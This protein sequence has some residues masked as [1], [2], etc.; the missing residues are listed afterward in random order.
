MIAALPKCAA[1]TLAVA[2]SL[3]GLPGSPVAEGLTPPTFRTKPKR[4]IGNLPDL[5]AR[6]A[7]SSTRNASHECLSRAVYFE[8]RGDQHLEGQLAVAQVV[9]NRTQSGLFPDTVCGVIRQPRQ[10]SFVRGSHIPSVDRSSTAWRR[11]V[12]IADIAISKSYKSMAKAALFFHALSVAPRWER[13]KIGRIG[14][15]IFYR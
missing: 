10:F 3:L 1:A 5:V 9:L 8:A 14:A 2:A 12:A 7:R 11:S 6:K 15:H 13:R 4:H